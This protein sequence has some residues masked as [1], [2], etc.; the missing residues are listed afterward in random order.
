MKRYIILLI[1]TLGLASCT[2]DLSEINTNTNSPI[3]AQPSLLFRKVLFDYGEQMS[4]EAFD[5]GNLLGQYFT[6][7]DFNNFDR[8]ALSEPL[9][10]GNPWPFIYKN[11][12]DNEIVLQKSI[13]NPTFAVYKGPALVM[14]AYMTAALTDLYGDV[15]YNEALKGKSQIFTPKYDKQ[16]DIYQGA[17]GILKNL[18]NAITAMTAYTGTNKLDGDIVYNGNLQNWI[19]FANSLRI[20]YLMRI[21][22]KVNVAAQLQAIYTAGNYIGANANNAV[23][24]FSATAPNNFRI[25]T[26]R[27]GDFSL[28]IMSKTAEEILKN[29]ND[30]RL[31]LFYRPTAGNASLYTGLIN[32]P[33]ATTNPVTVSNYSLTGTIFRENGANLKYNYMT[34]WETNFFLAEAAQKGLITAVPKTLYDLAV[35]QGFEYWNVTMPATYLT[36]GPALFNPL[37]SDALKLIITQK[38]IPNNLNGYEAWIEYRRTGFP[39]L[40]PVQASRNNGLYPVRMPYPQ[41]EST[42]NQANYKAAATATNNNSINT[43]V[44]WNN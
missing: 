7:I 2:K 1:A 38:W 36:T 44:W 16:E 21:S 19:K 6:M 34:A 28:Y 3:D 17:D 13:N 29:Y 35:T 42:L 40:K 15:P 30:P 11:L 8:H 10:A 39:L 26:T 20:K 5:A 18:E 33:D 37:S 41:E 31:S 9:Y 43:K 22:G 4:F 32:G 23:F 27:I 25:T 12:R 14:K 24:Q